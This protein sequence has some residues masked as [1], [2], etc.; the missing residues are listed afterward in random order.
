MKD[1]S[2]SHSRSGWMGIGAPDGAVGV[3]VVVWQ[4][5]FPLKCFHKWAVAKIA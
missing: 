2:S 5:D 1:A 4:L 3:P